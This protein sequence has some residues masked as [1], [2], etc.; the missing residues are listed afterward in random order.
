MNDFFSKKYIF[1]NKECSGCFFSWSL[2]VFWVQM[3]LFE[4]PLYGRGNPQA[5]R[6]SREGG[7]GSLSRDHSSQERGLCADSWPGAAPWSPQYGCWAGAAAWQGEQEPH[8]CTA[9]CVLQACLPSIWSSVVLAERPAAWGE[10]S[11]GSYLAVE[12]AGRERL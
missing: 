9:L 3:G 5:P 11:F 6:V 8:G 1:K 7:W 2:G 10:V 12:K 4:W